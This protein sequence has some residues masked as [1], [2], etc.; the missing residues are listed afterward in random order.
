MPL[1]WADRVRET[2]STSGTGAI[3][4]TG[5]FSVAFKTIGSVLA[6]GDTAYFTVVDGAGAWNTFLGTWNGSTVART[7]ILASSSAGAVSLSGTGVEIWIDAPADWIGTRGPGTVTSVTG[8]A[9]VT[10][11]GGA[12]PAISIPAATNAAAGHATAAHIAAIE[13]NTAK[14]TNA[15][16][17][18]DVTGATALTIA[19]NAVSNAKAAT[20]ATKTYKGRTSA[21]TGDA[22]DVAVATLKADLVLVKADVGLGSVD[23]TSDAAKPVSTAQQTALD[24]KAALSAAQTF[25]GAQRGAVTA[26][27]STAASIAINLA[28]NNNFSHTTS[29]NSTLAAPSNPVAGQ[30]GIIIITQGATARTLAYNA[31][32]KFAGGTI[33]TLTATASAVDAFA[34]Y[35]ESATRATCQL[36]KD[37]K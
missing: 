29:E 1:I 33:P 17:T 25:T 3:T 26:L 37:V 24:L 27:T 5:A 12:T 6:S 20:M 18:G 10:S 31:F 15:S 4:P 21:A 32:W 30:S 7:T 2:S 28:T 8:T 16:H 19:A 22:E 13:A 14:I 34:Y 9:P 11:S 36:I 23:D 35:V